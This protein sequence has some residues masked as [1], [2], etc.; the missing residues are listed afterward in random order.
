MLP[1]RGER[2]GMPAWKKELFMYVN[3][4]VFLLFFIGFLSHFPTGL[5][6]MPEGLP[7]GELRPPKEGIRTSREY[8][9]QQ[10]VQDIFV[11]GGCKNISNIRP[12][13]NPEGIGYFEQGST[14]IG[15]DKGILISTGH[16]I[17]AEGPNSE[18]D[19][20]GDLQDGS[21]DRDLSALASDRVLDAVGFEFDF[22]PLD[23][24]V[25]FR[26]VFASE[27]YCE[28]TGSKFNDVF[29][30]FISGPG[31]EGNFSNNG[32]NVALLPGSGDYVSINS[33]NHR[34][35]SEYYVG[36][37]LE[38]DARTC[39]K[40]YN[41]SE[42]QSLIEFD[43]FT[44]QLTAT[45]RLTPCET[46]HLRLVVG[47]VSD[48]LY[49]SAVF[50]EAESFNIG[51]EVT[52]AAQS[53][54]G[55]DV[56]V[57]GCPSGSFYFERVNKDDLSRTLE[58]PFLLMDGSTAEEGVDFEPLPRSVTIPA[59]EVS[60][61]LPVNAFNDG[62]REDRETIL[63]ELDYPCDC[64]TG[65]ATLALEDPA[66][67]AVEMEP[68]EICPGGQATL[69][70][71]ITGG[72]PDYSFEWDTDSR[73][74]SITVSPDENTTYEVAVTDACGQ[75]ASA[76]ALVSIYEPGRAEIDGIQM[77]CPGQEGILQIQLS[78]QAPW[79]FNYT[80][81]GKDQGTISGIRENPYGLTVRDEGVYQLVGFRDA[82]CA[83]LTSGTGRVEITR[84]NMNATT[85]G[86]SCHDLSDGRVEVAV[87]GGDFPYTYRWDQN[88]GERMNLQN[89]PPGTYTLTVTDAR[90][91][92]AETSATVPNPP[93]I[94]K[95]T[96]DCLDLGTDS[97]IFNTAGGSPP[98][99][100][101][102]DGSNFYDASLFPNLEPGR[103]YNLIIKDANGCRLEQEFIMPANTK[104][105]VDMEPEVTAILGQPFVFYPQLLIPNS[106]IEELR[107][108]PPIDLSCTEC[109][110][111]TLSPQVNRTYTLRVV[112]RFGCFSESTVIVNVNR[113]PSVF[114]PTA[115]SPNNDGHNDK[116]L[117]FA[118]IDQVRR[119]KFLQIFNRWG[120]LL[121]D[122][123]D[124]PP[125]HPDFGWDG[126]FRGKWQD[127]GVYV[128]SA[129]IE[130]I[131]GSVL[132][133]MGSVAL[134]R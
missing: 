33:V 94:E 112:D 47:D 133:K 117:I 71:I 118:D 46:Y 110:G 65:D 21:G 29:G 63:L 51:G 88:Q 113:Q 84:I 64:V 95:V 68:V 18:T 59:G 77:L 39:S 55:T 32:A 50:L 116:F 9:L 66:D 37:E 87:S 80:I 61:V 35:N 44:R 56:A 60:A 48:E 108:T 85:K 16:L 123:R 40:N 92:T 15:L 13:G 93:P 114:V 121:F 73:N 128:Y 22:V 19:R 4:K 69:S 36:N 12:I 102:V 100:F 6:A 34:R 96:F 67:I 90:G 28:Y 106:L 104:S 45:L 72:T 49:D 129:E 75:R 111:P 119:I 11:K 42:L 101:S 25:T 86:V 107:W 134:M 7:A 105:Y 109:L 10:L 98:Y 3:E 31:I 124:V 62:I 76:R 43:G 27:E 38:R 1:L 103:F 131:D 130:L 57:E 8:T 17:N 74:D 83:G 91:C 58:I 70:P 30:F 81:D 53:S 126:R 26:Y 99:Q 125:N 24:I 115:F 14:S 52:V 23:S 97:I 41:P 82:R 79:Q 127:P 78:G 20:S 122:V 120:N 132:K 54:V 89:V 5:M 2:H